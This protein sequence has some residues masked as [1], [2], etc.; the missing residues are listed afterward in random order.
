MELPTFGAK[1][2]DMERIGVVVASVREGRRG[3]PFA[4]W[5][6]GLAGKHAGVVTELID[7]RDWPLGPYEHKATPT[8]AEAGY[9][10]G[11][12]AQRWRDLV[13]SLD[14]FVFVTPEYN[15]GY[16][17]QLKNAIDWLW[18]AWHHKPCAFV[19]YG[20]SANGARAAEQL[21]SVAVEVRMVPIR[22]QVNIRLIGVQLDERGMPT[23]E[24][25]A[26]RT[27]AMLDEL[28]WLS[29]VLREAR[30]AKAQAAAK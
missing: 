17:G 16:P 10:D 4:Q 2:P 11:T 26:K 5:V 22:D 20:G 3:F 30:V 27:V 7:L 9:A 13:R 23:D 19:T 15:H 24:F 12:L 14:A 18:P 21:T 28:A 1:T 6:H 25:Y 8:V 29:Q